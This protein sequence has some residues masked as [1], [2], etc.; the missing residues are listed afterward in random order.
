MLS[1]GNLGRGANRYNNKLNIEAHCT[2]IN[3]ELFWSLQHSLVICLVPKQIKQNTE[4][5]KE[6]SNNLVEKVGEI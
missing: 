3:A 5:E 1:K 4:A 6:R 2:Q